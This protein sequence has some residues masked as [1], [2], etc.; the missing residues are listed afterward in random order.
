MARTK[1]RRERRGAQ[2]ATT[3]PTAAPKA[4]TAAPRAS[5]QGRQAVADARRRGPGP[6][7]R[8]VWTLRAIRAAFAAQPAA[9]LI[10]A[11]IMLAAFA[12]YVATAA[13]DIVFGDTPELT[14]VAL[15]AGVAHPPG[16]PVFTLIGWVFGQLPVGPPPFR[17]ALF[18]AVCH[19]LTVA[20]VYPT[21]FT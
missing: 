2:P 15:S 8:I 9:T 14:A 13:R 4:P 16:Y 6:R 11:A 5:Y 3:T 18:S 20:V 21:T 10:G 7:A 19:V 12:L 1:R 17:I